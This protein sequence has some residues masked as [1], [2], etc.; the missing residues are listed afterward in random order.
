MISKSKMSETT[1]EGVN[2]AREVP[3]K[4][5]VNKL[6]EKSVGGSI[7]VN[8]QAEVGESGMMSVNSLDK[9]APKVR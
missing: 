1:W 2:W 4:H 3:P 9:R 5:K 7:E 6:G 8:F